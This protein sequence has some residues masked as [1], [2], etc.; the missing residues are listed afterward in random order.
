MRTAAAFLIAIVL[1]GCGG[2]APAPTDRIVYVTP[3]PTTRIVYVTPE[4]TSTA[5]PT[6]RITA[7]PDPIYLPDPK[8]M[9]FLEKGS[10]IEE[11][12]SMEA[13]SNA[14][15]YADLDYAADAYGEGRALELCVKKE[16]A[17]LDNHKPSACYKNE[18]VKMHDYYKE[19]GNG[20]ADWNQWLYDFPYGSESTFNKGS[21]HIDEA[22]SN[23]TE[24]N[25]YIE[26][27]IDDPDHCM[28]LQQG[29][30]S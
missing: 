17:W 9:E 6:P 5:R 28:T 1:A 30:S 11:T 10:Q 19:M 4:P 13:L 20:L 7:T 25:I 23:L 22:L 3:E 27:A 16:M 24:A 26:R 29:T 21:A 18:W 2:S 14:M 15:G 8:Y 12:C